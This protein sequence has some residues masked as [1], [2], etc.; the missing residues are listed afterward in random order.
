M[1]NSFENKNFLFT[2]KLKNMKR[3]EAEAKVAA[4]G[5]KVVSGVTKNLSVLV[6]TSETSAKWAK[7]QELNSNGANIQLWT[8]EQFMAE[9]EKADNDSAITLELTYHKYST[10]QYSVND[11]VSDIRVVVDAFENGD[12][13]T[14][15]EIAECGWLCHAVCPIWDDPVNIYYSIK[16]GN[17]ELSK[18]ILTVDSDN[19]FENG[20]NE[21][22]VQ[23]NDFSYILISVDELKWSVSKFN[24]VSSDIDVHEGLLID[25]TLFD[26]IKEDSLYEELFGKTRIQVNVLYNEETDDQ[27]EADKEDIEGAASGVMCALLKY[28]PQEEKWE[29]VYLL[30][31]EYSAPR[32]LKKRVGN[33]IVEKVFEDNDD[34]CDEDDE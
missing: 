16:S 24:N 8:E 32:R 15:A 19:D 21:L 4:L 26:G 12:I 27:L 34:E 13:D 29:V 11:D 18:G 5:G 14:L 25:T 6:A 23:D 1:A 33:D 30:K 20:G 7:A 22:M 2:G 31:H 9:L 10:V 17:K 3:E 28:N